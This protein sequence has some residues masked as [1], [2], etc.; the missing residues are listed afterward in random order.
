MDER[1]LSEIGKEMVIK[2]DCLPLAIS[3]LGGVL[4]K[5]RTVK[6]WELVNENIKAYLYKGEGLEIH[7]V[8]NLSYEDLPYYL[9]PCFLYMVQFKE[10]EFIFADDLY[11]MWIAQ[12][13]I[14]HD[15]SYQG[16][17]ES[18]MDVAELYLSELVSRC[19]VQV[20]VED[21]A[22]PG[23]K[24]RK[25]KLHD[26]VQELCFPLAKKEDLGIQIL[27]Y[28]G[29]RFSTLLHQSLSAG[30]K[31]RYL[32]V[33][34][35]KKIDLELEYGASAVISDEDSKKHVRSLRLINHVH[36]E[37]IEFPHTTVDLHEF[38]LLRALV[39]KRFNFAGRRSPRGIGDLIHLRYLC[40]RECR[41][42]ELPSSISNLAW[43]HTLDLLNCRN[44][45][46]P[47]ALKKMPQ[48]KHLL[49]PSYDKEKM[50][51]Y[52]LKL[53]EGLDELET[54]YGFDSSIQEL[55]SITR[56]KKLRCFAG[57]VHDNKSLWK[58]SMLLLQTG[59]T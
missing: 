52:R 54:L 44:V 14:S 41:L 39:F 5:K 25:C 20:E 4:S 46:V 51:D 17:D 49:L 56:M 55:K 12:G 59:R 45:R 27:D 1:L 18:L 36:G 30:I 7:G 9:K 15:N 11:R 58:S 40:L 47:N 29:G 2:C 8:V 28:Q 33:H 31:A 34:F 6:E 57:T 3:L 50:G 10:D 24:Y 32:D 48:L 43:L 13:M 23:H 35:G 42:T 38:K 53:D 37:T 16:K 26:V 22:I 19:I 21:D